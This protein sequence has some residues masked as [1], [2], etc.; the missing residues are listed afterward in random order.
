MPLPV[1]RPPAPDEATRTRRI[2]RLDVRGSVAT[3]GDDTRTT[4]TSTFTDVF[5]LLR[6]PATGAWRIANKAYERMT[7]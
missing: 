5:V 7:A 1:H 3:A 2:E 4:E 6:D